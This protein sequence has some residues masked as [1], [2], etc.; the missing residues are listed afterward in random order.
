MQT[1][2]WPVEAGGVSPQSSQ[3][4]SI[5]RPDGGLPVILC[6]E[7]TE[8]R[9]KA[10]R[11]LVNRSVNWATWDDDLLA[12]KIQDLRALDYDLNLTG[13]MRR[14]STMSN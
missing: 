7:R 4:R 12:L 9:V 1:E 6:D 3:N 10:C 5:G 14:R 2:I 11:L 13:F 8:T